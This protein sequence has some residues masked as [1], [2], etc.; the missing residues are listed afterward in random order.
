MQKGL[1]AIGEYSDALLHCQALSA[2][3]FHKRYEIAWAW[4]Q[5]IPWQNSG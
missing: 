1:Q 2:Q 4:R 3:V 5:Q